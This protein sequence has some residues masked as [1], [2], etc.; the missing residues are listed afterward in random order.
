MTEKTDFSNA[1]KKKGKKINSLEKTENGAVALSTTDSALL[2]MLWKVSARDASAMMSNFEKVYNED[3]KLAYKFLFWIRDPR[4]GLGERKLFR[5]LFAYSLNLSPDRND[6]MKDHLL[7]KIAE[8]GRFDDGISILFDDVPR[9]N[10][11]ERRDEFVKHL[12]YQLKEDVKNKEA[13]KSISLLAKWMPSEN[14]SSKETRKKAK[15][16]RTILGW[17]PENYRKLLSGLRQYLDV[18]ERKMSANEWTKIDYEKVPSQANLKYNDAFLKHD[19]DNRRKFLEDL[20]K[21]DAKVNAKTLHPHQIIHSMTEHCS[22]DN[23]SLMNSMWKALPSYNLSDTLVIRDGSGSMY[24]ANIRGTK[25]KIATVC[26]ALTILCTERMEGPLKNQFITFSENPQYVN[27]SECE[28]LRSK[29]DFMR[30]FNDVSNTD[31]YKVFEMILDLALENDFKQED[32]PK[33]L[34]IVSDMQFDSMNHNSHAPDHRWSDTLFDSFVKKFKKH[35]YKIPHL[36]FWNLDADAGRMTVPTTDNELGITYLSGF[37]QNAL[38]MVLNNEMNP[39]KALL[40]TLERYD[41]IFD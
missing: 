13:G 36:V 26:D 3:P 19:T 18:V 39:M 11:K 14:T 28:D 8:Y 10:P 31:L 41:E 4:N 30:N 15:Q 27:L 2:D 16:I 32:L 24:S 12:A 6:E 21:G 23:T 17:T 1:L 38:E 5:D 34:L 22:E 33:R 20:K 29:L 25:I 9:Y 35:G 40:K 7:K 37:S